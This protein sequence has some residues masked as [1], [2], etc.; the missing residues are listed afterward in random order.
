MWMWQRL[1]RLALAGAACAPFVLGSA[2]VAAQDVEV[3]ETARAH[4]RRGV[5]LMQDPA[6]AR[7]A[8]ALAAFRL[9]YRESPS[10]K[11]LGNI[12]LCATRLERDGEAIRA[13][14]E[15]LAKAGPKSSKERDQISADLRL[16]KE[17]SGTVRLTLRPA[18]GTIVDRRSRGRENTYVVEGGSIELGLVAGT[19][20]LTFEA[21]GHAR[22]ELRVEVVAQ[23]TSEHEIT[24]TP[25]EPPAPR[26]RRP[27]PRPEPAVPS[28]DGGGATW[29]D[30]VWVGLA[31]TGAGA[32]ATAVV[33]GL[34]W[35]DREE[36]D[37]ALASGDL[38][39]AQELY[40]RGRT[41]NLAGDVLLGVTVTSAAATGIFT[42]L[43]FSMDQE[44]ASVAPVL[45]PAGAGLWLS[46]TTGSTERPRGSVG[47]H[48]G[49]R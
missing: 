37:D 31:L 6:G 43:H 34:A 14:E 42:L 13:Y 27:T 12:G 17:R 21:A 10:P 25:L 35:R 26:P 8:E 40:D 16:L 4:F 20:D 32:V 19:H 2:P 29:L 1:V 41:L 11:I 38:P 24:L 48:A 36:Y 47:S 5:A 46:F 22:G 39:R 18:A 9:A 33:G 44:T 45:S 49:H 30:A 15:Y 3:S 28:D 7:W 23:K